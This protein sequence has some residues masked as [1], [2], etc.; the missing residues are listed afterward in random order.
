MIREN[1]IN[2]RA[3]SVLLVISM[4]VTSLFNSL[5]AMAY[6]ETSEYEEN[7]GCTATFNTISGDESY[8]ITETEP[9][10][11]WGKTS[12]V[13]FANE[14]PSDLILEIE[15]SKIL[16]EKFEG[17]NENGGTELI[18]RQSLWYKVKLY[19]G[20]MPEDF[21][22]GYWVMQN[23]L[24]EEDAYEYDS[25]VIG[26]K[27]EGSI[28]IFDDEGNE[29]GTKIEMPQFEKIKLT[30]ACSITGDVTYQWQILIDDI[31]IDIYGQDKS[32]FTL[33][34]GVVA[35]VLDDFQAKIRLITKHH[36]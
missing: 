27:K 34:Y 25:L 31:W 33:T 1:N 28:S 7:I 10:D 5:I 18:E 36:L 32:E 16:T 12:L 29:V 14:I 35:S 6:V 24:N 11:S 3:I 20:T 19:S 30:G 21:A 9:D 26:E 22:D 17:F 13:Y 2:N 4:L 8:I 15:A 23:F